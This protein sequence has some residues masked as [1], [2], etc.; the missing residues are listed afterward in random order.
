M[1]IHLLRVQE[2][3]SG[4][5]APEAKEDWEQLLGAVLGKAGSTG[6]G[7]GL[8]SSS[9]VLELWSFASIALSGG[10]GRHMCSSI[11]RREAGRWW[12]IW[13]DG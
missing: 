5:R 2:V 11:A 6:W 10:P 8:L 7:T 3:G 12:L 4:L 13:T 1:H 9:A